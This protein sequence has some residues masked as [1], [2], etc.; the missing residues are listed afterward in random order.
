MRLPWR[1]DEGEKKEGYLAIPSLGLY[2]MIEQD[3]A[4]IIAYRRAGQGFLREVHQ[5]MSAIVPLP[6]IETELPLAEVYE[7]LELMPE[8]GGDEH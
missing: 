3:T 4:A 6:E 7:G 8:P 2:L 1:I 5:G